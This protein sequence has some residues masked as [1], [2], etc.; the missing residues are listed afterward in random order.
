VNLLERIHTVWAPIENFPGYEISSF[1]DV[2]DIS[3]NEV[4]PKAKFNNV[5]Y[6]ELMRDSKPY[7]M[8]VNRLRWSVFYQSAVP[9]HRSDVERHGKW[10]KDE[11]RYS[12]G[13]KSHLCGMVCS[14]GEV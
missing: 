14:V 2:R 7:L 4:L 12:D 10:I 5:D 8:H 13:E 9:S 3:T 6:V 11:M 1:G